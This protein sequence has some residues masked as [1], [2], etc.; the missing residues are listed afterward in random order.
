MKACELVQLEIC[1]LPFF[2]IFREPVDF[3][4]LWLVACGGRVPNKCHQKDELVLLDYKVLKLENRLIFVVFF[5]LRDFIDRCA[6]AV[7]KKLERLWV[8]V[9]QNGI[10]I[11]SNEFI[12]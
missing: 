1:F 11:E 6:I 5:E 12:E 7:N 8:F 10:F 3:Y 9:G 4:E 2:R